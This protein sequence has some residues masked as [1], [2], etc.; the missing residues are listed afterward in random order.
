MKI[1]KILALIFAVLMMSTVLA[2]CGKTEDTASTDDTKDATVV[3]T[4]APTTEVNVASGE[5]EGTTSKEDSAATLS[6]VVL[7]EV[8]VGIVADPADFAPFSNPSAGRTFAFWSI[9]QELAHII[10][11][12][13][14]GVLMKEYTI[15]EDGLSMDVELYDYIYDSAGN[16]ITASDA[17]YSWNTTIDA[18][19]MRGIQF[20]DSMEATGDYTFKWTFNTQLKIGNLDTLFKWYIFSQDAYEASADGMSTDPIGTGHYELTD[21]TSGY[22]FTYEARDDYW[23][24]DEALIH[25]RDMANVKKIN[26]YIIAESSQMTIA[27]ENGSIDMSSNVSNDDIDM[28]KEGGAQSDKYWVYGVPDNL[29]VQFYGN[30]SEGNV[31]SDVNLRKAVFYAVSAESILESVFAG[32]GTTCHDISPS[33]SAGYNPAWDTED[34]YYNYNPE[35]AKEYLAKSS[36]NG[37]KLKILCENTPNM[38]NTATLVQSF[39]LQ[40]GIDS[41]ILAVEGSLVNTYR[42]DP[43]YWDLFL[44]NNACNTYTAAGWD[45]ALSA[46]RQK[47]GGTMGFA[48]DDKLQEML[49][50]SLTL[51]TSNEESLNAVHNYTIENAYGMNLVNY[52]TSFV[53]PKYM[54]SI[55]LSYKKTIIPGGCVYNDM[56]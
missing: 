23:Q 43:T 47:W 40:I 17:I 39:L 13:V 53:V 11:G 26:Y 35:T 27:L 21:Y 19:Q 14:Y 7:D 16:N 2:A 1:K 50:T 20:V 24:T 31:C 6:S 33:W 25:A 44:N 54:D 49:V 15:A 34:N 12:K 46:G 4:E 22:M 48:M 10:D 8:N 42:E 29:S 51:S 32:N 37:E 28:F 18:G 9:F 5:G 30:S 52:R 45:F 55:T 56:E 3:A 41:E 38:T 36:Y